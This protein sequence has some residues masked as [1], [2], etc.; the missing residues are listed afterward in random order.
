MCFLELPKANTSC[1]T[2]MGFKAAKA[3]KCKG[4]HRLREHTSV[5]F[6]ASRGQ[7]AAGT[8]VP[9]TSVLPFGR[10]VADLCGRAY[11]RGEKPWKKH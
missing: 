5:Y 8:E 6:S 10:T 3:M 7:A 4:C 2:L 11:T 1:K 9:V